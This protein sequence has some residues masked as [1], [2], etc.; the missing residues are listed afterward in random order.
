MNDNKRS[1]FVVYFLGAL[2]VFIGLT[3]LIFGLKLRKLVLHIHSLPREVAT[4]I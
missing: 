4:K 3:E 1:R 2:Q